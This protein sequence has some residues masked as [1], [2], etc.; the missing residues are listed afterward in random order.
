M[1]PFHP[2]HLTVASITPEAAQHVLA[3]L[4]TALYPSP[5]G[6]ITSLITTACIADLH[7]LD[8]LAAGFPAYAAAVYAYKQLNEGP[9]ALYA[10]A[11]AGET[12]EAVTAVAAVA[13]LDDSAAQ[14]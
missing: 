8:R 12:I 6:F 10:L 5:S 11:E 7:N 4:D 1:T 14:S 9:A 3:V 2:E 13:M